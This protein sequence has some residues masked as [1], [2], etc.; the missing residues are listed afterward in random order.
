MDFTYLKEATFKVWG[1]KEI[2]IY[3]YVTLLSSYAKN[4]ELVKGIRIIK[5]WLGITKSGSLVIGPSWDDIIWQ[6]SQKSG[7][8]QWNTGEVNVGVGF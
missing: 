7:W 3:F 8:D 4:G 2:N 6:F 5:D 1:Q